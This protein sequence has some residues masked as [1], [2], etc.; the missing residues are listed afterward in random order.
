MNRW[1]ATP[2]TDRIKVGRPYAVSMSRISVDDLTNDQIEAIVNSR[3]FQK[4]LAYNKLAEG[5]EVLRDQ[6][7]IFDSMVESIRK[8]HTTVN[9][10]DSIRQFFDLFLSEVEAFTKPLVGDSDENVEATDI[11]DIFLDRD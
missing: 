11:E 4:M 10:S 9:S 5:V 7:E 8:Q 2:Y 3:G 6:D 1:V